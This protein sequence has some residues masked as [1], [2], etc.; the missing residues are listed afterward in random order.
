MTTASALLTALTDAASDS[1]ASELVAIVEE[2]ADTEVLV[3]VL[4]ATKTDSDG[5]S[6]V[7]CSVDTITIDEDLGLPV[8]SEREVE[9]GDAEGEALL[10]G[11]LGPAV[12]IELDVRPVED[13]VLDTGTLDGEVS[14]L[15][16]IEN[17]AGILSKSLALAGSEDAGEASDSEVNDALIL[18]VE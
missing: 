18:A 16:G 5:F 14:S 2:N 4:A 12:L 17:P 15:V 10:G 6:T 8:T 13:A 9:G 7:T 3:L 11:L 1:N